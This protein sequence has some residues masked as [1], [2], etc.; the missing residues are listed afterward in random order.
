MQKNDSDI[1]N[2]I[3]DCFPLPPQKKPQTNKQTNEQNKKKN[4]KKNRNW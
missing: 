1:L 3:P 2:H 4:P